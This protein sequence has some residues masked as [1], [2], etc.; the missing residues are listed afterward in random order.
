VDTR[1]ENGYTAVHLAAL[2]GTLACVQALLDSGA[3]M[4][5][6]AWTVTEA[7]PLSGRLYAHYGGDSQS[8][9]FLSICA[10][11]MLTALLNCGCLPSS[12]LICVPRCGRLT[13]GAA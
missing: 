1:S 3:S 2:S 12:P 7:E 11:G 5:V 4:M 6:R 9:G 8:A 10:T 13:K